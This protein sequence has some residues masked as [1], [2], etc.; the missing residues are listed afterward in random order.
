MKEGMI[1]IFWTK[2]DLEK[3][4]M[5]LTDVIILPVMV[6]YLTLSQML[7]VIVCDGL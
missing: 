7:F 2:S 6:K 5:H 1:E 3:F 4:K